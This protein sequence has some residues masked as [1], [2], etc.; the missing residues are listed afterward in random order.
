MGFLLRRG[1]GTQTCR[2]QRA[3]PAFYDKQVA[4]KTSK[5]A[6]EEVADAEVVE[7]G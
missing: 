6:S 5:S 3:G 4:A 7:R 1:T 2:R